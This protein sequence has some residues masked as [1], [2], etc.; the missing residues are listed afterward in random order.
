MNANCDN[1]RD[2]TESSMLYSS[3]FDLKVLSLVNA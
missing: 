1:I 2:T 3:M